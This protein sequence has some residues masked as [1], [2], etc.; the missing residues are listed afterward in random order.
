M[1]SRY[2]AIKTIGDTAVQELPGSISTGGAGNAEIKTTHVIYIVKL[3]LFNGN[4]AVFSGV[5]L[6][7]ITVQ[8][9]KYPLQ[10]RVDIRNGY[11]QIGGDM[12]NLPK[13][14]R[15]VG[16]NTDFMIGKKYLRYYPEKIFQLP[17]YLSIY[18]SWFKNS[19]VS[20]GVSIGGPHDYMNRINLSIPDKKFP[21]KSISHV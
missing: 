17:S 12:T 6:D 9:P 4:D 10:G 5:C 3:P 19:D 13:L 20:R 11:K 16:E 2:N 15:Y 1:V 21:V 7:Q 14:P 18:K 8:F